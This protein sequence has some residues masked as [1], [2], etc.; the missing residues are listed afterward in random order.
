MLGTALSPRL[1]SSTVDTS[2]YS[3]VPSKHSSSPRFG[4]HVF[5]G[6]GIPTLLPQA[7]LPQETIS[8]CWGASPPVDAV[9]RL[10]LSASTSSRINR[11]HEGTLVHARTLQL[12]HRRFTP[13]ELPKRCLIFN[14]TFWYLPWQ[15]LNIGSPLARILSLDLLYASSLACYRSMS[16]F[17]SFV[18]P[19]SCPF[20]YSG[21]T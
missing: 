14:L 5:R 13:A 21:Y 6:G 9:V 1:G 10:V 12:G 11:C 15:Y 2:A 7:R 19:L 3:H 8:L 4:S 16:P 18:V 20:F 17:S